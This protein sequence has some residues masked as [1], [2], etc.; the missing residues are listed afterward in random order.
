MLIPTTPPRT[1]VLVKIA[2]PRIPRAPPDRQ[3]T[4]N[5]MTFHLPRQV[6]AK[7]VAGTRPGAPCEPVTAPRLCNREKCRSKVNETDEP[8]RPHA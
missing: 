6:G 1:T 7:R 5:T 8:K 4:L 2:M 3:N